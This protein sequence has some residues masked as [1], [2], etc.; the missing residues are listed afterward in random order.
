[1]PLYTKIWCKNS[2]PI[3]TPVKKPSGQKPV[4]K[5][6]SRAIVNHFFIFAN[7]WKFSSVSSEV[8]PIQTIGNSEVVRAIRPI[9]SEN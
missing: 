2:T 7:Y 5:P 4:K 8:Y 6:L 9:L 1:M 3:H